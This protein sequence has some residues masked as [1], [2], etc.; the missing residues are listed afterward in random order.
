MLLWFKGYLI[1]QNQPS[2]WMNTSLILYH[3]KPT[4]EFYQDKIIKNWAL[5]DTCPIFYC[6]GYFYFMITLNRNNKN[7]LRYEDILLFREWNSFS[8]ATKKIYKCFKHQWV[9]GWHRIVSNL[10]LVCNDAEESIIASNQYENS[11]LTRHRHLAIMSNRRQ[12]E[13]ICFLS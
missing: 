2:V 10:T 9:Y 8:N 11:S 13:R 12:K 4:F 3:K 6:R 5:S 7:Q 1:G